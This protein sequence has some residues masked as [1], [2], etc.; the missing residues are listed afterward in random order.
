LR[1]ILFFVAAVI[2]AIG[3]AGPASAEAVSLVGAWQFCDGDGCSQ[4][5]AFQPNGT[6]IKQYLLL[7]TTVTAY[8]HYKRQGDTLRI[9][10]TRF[11]PKRVCPP[12]GSAAGSKCRPTAEPAAHGPIRFDGL[13]ALVW[14]MGPRPLRL[15]R[16]E[17]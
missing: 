17:E 9:G 15:V 13:N 7:G 16:I 8:G 6:V 12:K 10:W 5:F 1:R 14:S 2:L 11:S 3:A 4:R